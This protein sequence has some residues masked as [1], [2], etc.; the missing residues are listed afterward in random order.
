MIIHKFTIKG[1]H[2][3]PKGN[4][5]PKVK[6][7]K[8][9]QW[10]PRAQSYMQWKTFVGSAFIESIISDPYL[11][12][13]YA[14][15]AVKYGKPIVVAPNAGALMKLKIYWKNEAHADPESVFGSI[16]DALFENDKHLNGEFKYFHSDE[17]RVEVEIIIYN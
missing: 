14:K 2:H 17:G 12:T 15:N 5:M 13:H 1:N 11:R 3:D 4:A 8:N 16:A 6:L 9:Q 7:T 10:T